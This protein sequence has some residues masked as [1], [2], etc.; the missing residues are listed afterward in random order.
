[1]AAKIGFIGA[2]QMASALMRGLISKGV[3][4]RGE[5]AACD[6]WAPAREKVKKE[7]GV[8]VFEDASQVSEAAPFLVLAVKPQQMASVFEGG[9]AGVGRGKLVMSIAAGVPIETL[10]RYVPDGRIIRVMPNFCC[11][12]LCSASCFALG[13][14]ATREDADA[15]REVLEAVGMAFEVKEG[16]L[17]AVTGLSGSAPAYMF[18]AMEAMADGGV[19]CGLP[20]DLSVKLAAQTMLGAARTVLETGRHPAQLKDSVCSPGGTTIEGVRALEEGGMRAALI[21]AVKAGT[22]RSRE[23]GGRRRAPRPAPL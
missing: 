15:V 3:C 14:K 4:S 6:V 19:L 2:G 12:V 9:G 21:A 7:L 5:I 22:E 13:S 23:L 20:R 17:D 16:D 11:T 10:E 1:M 18:M 8:E